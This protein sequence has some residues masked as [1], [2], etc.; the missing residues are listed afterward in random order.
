MVFW[1]GQM[2]CATCGEAVDRTSVDEHACDTDR[3]VEFQMVAL[4]HQ[5]QSFDRDLRAFLDGNDGRF[6]TWLAAR[7]VRRSGRSE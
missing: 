1:S 4:R 6:E 2:P 3:R 7:Q 5:M